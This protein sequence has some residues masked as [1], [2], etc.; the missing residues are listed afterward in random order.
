MAFRLL[1]LYSL[2][3]LLSALLCVPGTMRGY[4]RGYTRLYSQEKQR[5][6]D[7]LYDSHVDERGL[8]VE[9]M[10]QK[11]LAEIRSK[12]YATERRVLEALET[13]NNNASKP[14]TVVWECAK[15][16]NFE[17]PQFIWFGIPYIKNRCNKLT[18][19]ASDLWRME[20]IG[21]TECLFD[22]NSF[23]DLVNQHAI[24]Q[25]Y[26][27]GLWN[28]FAEY[29]AEVERDLYKDFYA[30]RDIMKSVSLWNYYPEAVFDFSALAD[31][32]MLSHILASTDCRIIL[33]TG[34]W[35]AGAIEQ[36]LIDNAGYKKIHSFI[37]PTTPPTDTSNEL[38]TLFLAPLDEKP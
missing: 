2:S 6:I 7:I 1:Q 25:N 12:L 23:L 37:K 30:Y 17:N 21:I 18:F 33:Y 22:D 4:V 24:K 28:A 15:R 34:G 19:H 31:I 5:T 13:L 16:E 29:V 3:V 20:K 27:D 32:E 9:D 10:E 8:S 38:N 11:P 14:I 35:H 26:G 36:F